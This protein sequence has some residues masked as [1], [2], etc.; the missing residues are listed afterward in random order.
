MAGEFKKALLWH[1]ERD[2]TTVAALAAAT[3]VSSDIIKKIRS[4]SRTDNS[5]D[6]E[7][8]LLIAAYYGKNVNQFV[9]CAD[10]TPAERAANLLALLEPSE[11]QLLETQIQALVARRPA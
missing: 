11:Q 7:N 9:Q 1:M 8:A 6:V 5:T 4:P 2:G 10:V 3:G